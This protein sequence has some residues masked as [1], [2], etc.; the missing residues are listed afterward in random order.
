MVAVIF[1]SWLA[2]LAGSPH[3]VGMCGA[4]AAAGSHPGDISAHPAWWHFGRLTTYAALGA[5]AG[6]FGSRLP[7]PGWLVHGFALLLLVIFAGALAGVIR[8][9]HM[10]IPGVAALASRLYGRSGVGYRF[11]FGLV[12]GLLPCG[13]VYTAL[14]APLAAQHAWIGAASMVAFGL[15]TVPALAFGAVGVQK[16]LQRGVWARRGVAT[17]VLASGIWAIAHRPPVTVDEMPAC[18]NGH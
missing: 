6:A 11:A 9:L 18:H 1:G 2:G 17:L 13:L 8:P 14:A 12:S 10:P 15:G 16:L 5:L 4:F 3:C 7:G